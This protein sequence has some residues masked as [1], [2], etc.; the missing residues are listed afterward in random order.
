MEKVLIVS[1]I[2]IAAVSMAYQ[3]PVEKQSSEIVISGLLTVQGNSL[4]ASSP[5][6]TSK[7]VK[8]I[9]MVLTGYSSTV[10][11]TDSD[12]FTTAAGTQVR[13]GIVATNILPFGTRIILP[14]LYD[15]KIFVVE[16]R[17]SSRKGYHI[18]I[19]FPSRYE[20]LQFG[21]KRTEVYVLSN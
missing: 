6:P 3:P 10:D 9:T 4:I 5:L 13:K 18:D 16:D 12:P 17:M 20:A 11:Q 1:L 14:E 15:D 19:W 2:L 21:V 7:V 8:T